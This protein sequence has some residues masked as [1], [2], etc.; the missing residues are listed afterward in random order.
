M[1]CLH[2]NYD[3]VNAATVL[4]PRCKVHLPSLMRDMLPPGARLH[5]GKYSVDYA[6]GQGG[7][8]ITYLGR[9][10]SLKKMVAIK[11]FYPQ[12]QVAREATTGQIVLRTSGEDNYRRALRR[13]MREGETLATLDHPSV[14]RVNDQ[15]EENGTAYLVMDMI[16]GRTLKDKL[17]S[18]PGRC[19]PAPRVHE[20]VEQLVSAPEAVHTKGVYHLDI[21]P[22]NIILRP[23]GRAVLVDF[24]ASK[25]GLGTKS[26]QAFTLE[27]AA[28]EVLAS[29]DIGPE[30][31]IFEVG[32]VLHE[33]LTGER[34]PSALSRLTRGGWEAKV[35]GDEWK[36]LVESA[37]Q[38]PR[39][40]RP[41]SIR[42]WW[43]TGRRVPHKAETRTASPPPSHDKSAVAKKVSPVRQTSAQQDNLNVA[44]T[45]RPRRFRRFAFWA[46]KW[47]LVLAFSVGVGAGAYAIAYG[48]L[49]PSYYSYPDYPSY[50]S[51]SSDKIKMESYNRQMRSYD[52][53]MDNYYDWR[54]RAAIQS[55]ALGG[56]AGGVT[57][58]VL[59]VFLIRR[60]RRKKRREGASLGAV[61]EEPSKRGLFGRLRRKS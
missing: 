5:G 22:D 14:V 53:Q 33:M 10:T 54:N 47:G 37:L 1:R 48:M 28:P 3:G 27:Y 52:I 59:T 21:K 49:K 40:S 55:I 41:Q 57:F 16:E 17:D 46:I 15:F 12:E 30:S 36:A 42:Q 51:N 23:D 38:L 11:E 29:G 32:M 45:K 13:F 35:V 34:P 4:C 24:G 26:T 2:C 19:L 39:D 58:I 61:P 20:I 56:V 31:D 7:F 8:G 25:Q 18:Q 6:L 50:P 60:G 43:E 9:H 44:F